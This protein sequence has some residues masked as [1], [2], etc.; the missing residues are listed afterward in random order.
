M[1]YDVDGTGIDLTNGPWLEQYSVRYRHGGLYSLAACP[2][3]IRSHDVQ[4]VPLSLL[5]MRVL[6]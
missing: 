3:D 4:I 1:P 5:H 6:T 2:C